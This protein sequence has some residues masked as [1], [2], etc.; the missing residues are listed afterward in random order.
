M[1]GT[2]EGVS[3]KTK[4]DQEDIGDGKCTGQWSEFILMSPVSDLV[5]MAGDKNIHWSCTIVREAFELP[6]YILSF[7]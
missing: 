4:G 6:V 1:Q 2:F 7:F 5:R 3:I